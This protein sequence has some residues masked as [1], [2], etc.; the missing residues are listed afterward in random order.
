MPVRPP[1]GT[2]APVPLGPFRANSERVVSA[3]V[4]IPAD[5]SKSLQVKG[6]TACSPVSESR[7]VARRMRQQNTQDLYTHALSTMTFALDALRNEPDPDGTL[8]KLALRIEGERGWVRSLM[9]LGEEHRRLR[10]GAALLKGAFESADKVSGPREGGHQGPPRLR[11]R[12]GSAGSRQA[13]CF[14][15]PLTRPNRV[16][17]GVAGANGRVGP[18]RRRP[19]LMAGRQPARAAAPQDWRPRLPHSCRCGGDAASLSWGVA[20]NS[21]P[22]PRASDRQNGRPESRAIPRTSYRQQPT[23]GRSRT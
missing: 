1:D 14:G 8:A 19:E 20:V 7:K 10:A 11:L 23:L 6:V 3:R 13:E 4:C 17:E 12:S 22:A 16:Q 18:R 5:L 2:V 21:R 9:R 15:G